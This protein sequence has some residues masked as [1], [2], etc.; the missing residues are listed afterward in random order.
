M[1]GLN[2]GEMKMERIM[3]DKQLMELHDDIRDGV[4]MIVSCKHYHDME[5]KNKISAEHIFECLKKEYPILSEAPLRE[6]I[7]KAVESW[8]GNN[9]DL[10]DSPAP[11]LRKGGY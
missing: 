10:W 6:S 11:P 2:K 4:S 5:L 8:T 1:D 3:T 7:K 9:D